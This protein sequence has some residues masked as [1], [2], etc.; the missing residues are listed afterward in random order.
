M[1]AVCDLLD[2]R[3]L[4]TRHQNTTS[5]LMN[6]RFSIRRVLNINF[7]INYEQVLKYLFYLPQN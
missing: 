2:N 3:E 5:R 7:R 4:V 6:H 1:G